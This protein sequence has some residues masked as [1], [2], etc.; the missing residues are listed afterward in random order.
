M[1]RKRRA[2]PAMLCLAFFALGVVSAVAQIPTAT[3]LGVV[4]DTS[5]AVL[6]G[7]T[8]TARNTETGMTRTTVTDTNGS[9]RLSALQVGP[10]ELTIELAG[11]RSELR[12]GLTLS[13]S[14]EAVVD[15][16]LDVGALSETLTVTADAPLVNTTSGAL[17][18][19]IDEQKIADLPLNGRNYIDLTLMQPGIAQSRT[20]GTQMQYS[21]TWF[22]SSGA[23]PR[24]NNYM[25]D[26]AII[27]NAG[28]VSTASVTGQTLGVEGIREYRVMTNS[29][30]AEYGIAMGSQ[31]NIVSKNG[32]NTFHGSAFEYHRNDALDAKNFFDIQK[33]RFTRN[34]FGGSFGGPIQTDKTF[35]HV[36][37]ETVREQRGRT[38][39]STTMP[40]ADKLDGTI[41]PAIS[42]AIKPLLALYPAPNLPNNQF[43]FTYIQPAKEIYGQVRVD[44]NFSSKDTA[45]FRYTVND[46]ERVEP[47]TFPDFT[48]AGH[49]RNQFAT[50]SENHVFTQSVLNTVRLS[51]SNPT[52][53]I[54]GEFP[55]LVSTP[56]FQFQAGQTMGRISV[57][58]LSQVGTQ[59]T[60][61]RAF[62]QG[63]ITFSDDVFITEGRSAWKMGMLW[64]HYRQYLMQSF[65]RGGSA[66]FANERSF[67][68]G[69]ATNIGQ[70]SAGSFN[71][72]TFLFSIFGFYAQNDLK[73][74]SGLTLNLGLRY[75]F[76]TDLTEPSGH[77]SAIRD[78]VHDTAATI[79]VPYL[80]PSKKNFSPRLGFAWD[81]TGN[82]KTSIKG[83][84]GL[85]YDLANLGTALVQTVSGTPPF[86]AFNRVVNPPVFT[87]PYQIPDVAFGKSTRI[88]DYNLQQPHMLQYNLA[89]ERQLPF[90]TAVS[91][92]YGGSRGYNLL[93]TIE[94]NPTIPQV[95]PDGRLFWT[96][97]ERRVNPAWDDMEL[98]TA[99][100][101]SWYNSVQF[102]VNKRMTRGLQFQSALTLSRS[103]DTTATVAS[104][105]TGGA[106]YQ[107]PQ[108]PYD[109]SK[110]KGPSPWDVPYSWR[111]NVIYRI[112]DAAPANS[113][114]G[115]LLN[116]WQVAGI[117]A[118]QGGQPFTP[119]LQSNRSRS[120]VLAGPAG[121]ERPDLVAGVNAD[122][123]TSDVSRGCG[124][125]AAGTPVGTAQLWFDPCAFS[126]PQIGTLGNVGRNT[127]RLPG[128]ASIDIS[129]MKSVPI[130]ALGENGRI[131]IRADAFNLLNRVNLGQ[132]SRIVYAATQDVQAPLA[133]AGQITTA[134]D[135][136][137][138]QLSLKLVF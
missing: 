9:Y 114:A 128:F 58:G 56:P 36:T 28:G 6:P 24:S 61:P 69:Q 14:Q 112:P 12:K 115:A 136:R 48:I 11:F 110:E 96:G 19:L 99:M 43:A 62:K 7:V 120:K 76:Q 40:A 8:L 72:K 68:L 60:Y 113:A 95:L 54:H 39:I 98:K 138:I 90:D 109:L 75:E 18:A 82:G 65:E 3:I 64:N 46:G 53:V 119:G 33:P 23:P 101:D 44:R 132:P 118:V 67:L 127:L 45:F 102:A 125:I 26:G 32:T 66:T 103:I 106:S 117:V 87:V 57:G 74:S 63:L 38:I 16:V 30:S 22:S 79:G 105:D 83:G 131:E 89:V 134:G 2:V 91:V 123:I 85:L 10:Y 29:F 104:V 71:D 92:A 4:K 59:T 121:L 88:M 111:F 135:A 50:F 122:E 80:N 20:T 108:N 77:S 13:A 34:N 15:S 84:A 124:T 94:G 5:G 129:L 55:D 52:M 25:L 1:N 107:A 78:R 116:G 130:R 70:P 47:D 35:F 17:G 42:P 41:V 97:T 37:V 73:V 81:V 21:G 27:S 86:A 51:Y 133:T 49:T 137:Q 31:M 100:A 93:T 126:I